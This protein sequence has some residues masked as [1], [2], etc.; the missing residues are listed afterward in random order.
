M[1]LKNIWYKRKL[2]ELRAARGNKCEDCGNLEG[3]QFHH[4]KPTKLSGPG[5]GFNRRVLDI[6]KH[7]DCYRLVCPVCHR[8]REGVIALSSVT[9]ESPTSSSSTATE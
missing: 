9:T 1:D 8:A 3:L 7:P 2:R 5:R 4:I 6:M